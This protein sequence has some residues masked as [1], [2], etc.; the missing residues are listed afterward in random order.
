MRTRS[1]PLIPALL[2]VTG[3]PSG[4]A[5]GTE[6]A[7]VHYT[8]EVDN[9][10]SADISLGEPIGEAETRASLLT[11]DPGKG[12]IQQRWGIV[13]LR[14][15]VDHGPVALVGGD[16]DDPKQWNVPRDI[17]VSVVESGNFEVAVECWPRM[18]ESGS[19]EVFAQISDG[20]GEPQTV[21]TREGVSRYCDVNLVYGGSNTMFHFAAFG[22][23]VV[24]GDKSFGES[25]EVSEAN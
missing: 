10:L 15:D 11:F 25:L 18:N 14:V 19:G 3:C 7:K 23:G 13:K 6:V 5:A 4:T 24:V 21:L 22:D 1:L 20:S 12:P 17:R 9:T 16:A 2:T 8:A